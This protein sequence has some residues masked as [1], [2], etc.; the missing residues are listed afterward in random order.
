MKGDSRLQAGGVIAKG[1]FTCGAKRRKCE[2]GDG[3]LTATELR[4]R[5]LHGA[6][7]RTNSH[8][9]AGEAPQAFKADER[10][11]VEGH[12]TYLARVAMDDKAWLKE[13]DQIRK[14]LFGLANP[15]TRPED[16]RDWFLVDSWCRQKIWGSWTGGYYVEGKTKLP[17]DDSGYPTR[18]SYRNSC[19]GLQR[20]PNVP[21]L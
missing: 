18:A 5:L 17:A 4:T 20:P 13:F 8:A 7:H 3:K 15:M 9:P 19:T 1:A 12:G 2:L 6:V 11:M 21:P 10:Y 14:P 16:E